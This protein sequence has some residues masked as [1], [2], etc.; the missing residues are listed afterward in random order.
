MDGPSGTSG[1]DGNAHLDCGRD[2]QNGSYQ[3]II[4]HP[5]IGPATYNDKYDL[6]LQEF[7]LIFDEEDGIV[8]PGEKG[9]VSAVTL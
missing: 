6:K 8:E 7:G 4:E 1:H 3:F 5:L 9:Y 2:G